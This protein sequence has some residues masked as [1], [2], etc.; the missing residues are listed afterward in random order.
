MKRTRT[1]PGFYICLKELVPIQIVRY[2]LLLVHLLDSRP[3]F[4]GPSA[5]S[6]LIDFVVNGQR[7]RG[8]IDF[9]S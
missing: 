9:D 7:L 8:P 3:K 6:L 5:L 2:R 1:G 4:A